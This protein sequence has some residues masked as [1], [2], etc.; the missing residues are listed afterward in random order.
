MRIGFRISSLGFGGAERV[1]LSLAKE[2]KN[3]YSWEVDFIVDSALGETYILAEKNGFNLIN[4]NVS[5]TYKS[6]KPLKSYFEQFRPDV[7]ISAYTETNAACV[8]SKLFSNYKPTIIISEHA[9]IKEHWQSKSALKKLVL[10][11]IVRGIYRLADGHIGV[12]KGVSAQIEALCN[13]KV[14]TIYNPVRF[15]G[16]NNLYPKTE[17]ETDELRLLSVGRIS[18]PK[19]Y[20]TLLKSL[21][22]L[23]RTRKVKLTIVG[24]IYEQNEYKILI[25][26]ISEHT[27]QEYVVFAGFTES[28]ESYYKNADV[29]VLS[30]AWE[31][32]G[33]V[34][35]EAMSF[36]LPIVSTNCNYG[37]SE[38]L[39]DGR[40]GSLVDVG[41]Y[42]KLA[43]LIL[44][45]AESPSE[46]PQ[47]LI[48]RSQDFSEKIIANQYKDYIEKAVGKI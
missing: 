38:I 22:I 6:I 2:F 7:I 42:Q 19:N 30:S 5:R 20:L 28:V 29:F 47:N 18:E 17:T 3:N 8:L 45:E 9:S 23:L 48:K 10:H 26:F 25:D 13:H 46:T 27:L 44:K 37:P 36:G 40:Y 16:T 15:Q 12:S 1:F 11:S 41:D 39:E 32:F 14:E 35:I 24:G 31:G 43:N 33:N 4:L 34:I 21:L